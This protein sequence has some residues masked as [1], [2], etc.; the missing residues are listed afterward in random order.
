MEY[1]ITRKK[2]VEF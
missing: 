2:S 1:L